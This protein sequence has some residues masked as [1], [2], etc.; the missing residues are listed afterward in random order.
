[1]LLDG[2]PAADATASRRAALVD[3]VNRL[4]ARAGT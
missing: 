4:T 2:T 1:M 3:L